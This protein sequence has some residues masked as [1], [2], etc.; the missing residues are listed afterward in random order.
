[1]LNDF[2]SIYYI[3]TVFAYSDWLKCWKPLD[4]N[5]RYSIKIIYIFEV[6]SGKN[7]QL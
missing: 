5:N 4:Y 7:V 3:Y 1:M 6:L 2:K